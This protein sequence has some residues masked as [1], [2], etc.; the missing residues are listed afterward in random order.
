MSKF[1]E[2]S[3]AAYNKKAD[4]YDNTN[5]GRFTL[6]FKRLLVDCIAVGGAP[7]RVTPNILD[8]ACG[9][10]TL[11]AMLDGK[12]PI[13]GFGI[14]IS[15]Q[16]IKNAAARNPKMEFHAAGCEAMPF[17]D[18]T[19]DIITVCAAYHHFPDVD[20]F[21]QEA[22]RVLKAGGKIYIAEIYLPAIVRLIINPF[23]PLSKAGDV[24]FYSP[25]EIIGN[26]SRHGFGWADVTIQGS[27]QLVSMQK[28][29]EN[30]ACLNGER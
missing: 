9:N 13:N 5:D 1:N 29:R 16:M 30:T 26:L 25:K 8:V 6:K 28:M 24:K 17:G 11:L 7:L 14:D 10:G 20:T 4:D 18:G 19:M 12:T 3:R 27:I 23:V 15:D 2:K 22:G 21:A